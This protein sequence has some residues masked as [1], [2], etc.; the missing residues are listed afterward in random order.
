MQTN[1]IFFHRR[2]P[3][4]STS[5]RNSVVLHW[6]Q[7]G[8]TWINPFTHP[9]RLDNSHPSHFIIYLRNPTAIQFV[10]VILLF[11]T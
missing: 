4:L 11:N 2:L 9:S 6:I 3:S 1:D 8:F 7:K 5:T 10:R